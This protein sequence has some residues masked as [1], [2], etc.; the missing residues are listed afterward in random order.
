[1][2][3][4]LWNRLIWNRL[5]RPRGRILVSVSTFGTSFLTSCGTDHCRRPGTL[6]LLLAWVR[7]RKWP[8]L[9]PRNER[10]PVNLASASLMSFGDLDWIGY[11]TWSLQI[12]NDQSMELNCMTWQKAT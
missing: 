8:P 9:Q 5:I 3:S 4:K 1:M 10:K 6:S 12:R 2:H 7:D 11:F